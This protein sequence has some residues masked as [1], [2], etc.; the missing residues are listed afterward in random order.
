MWSK[1]GVC[2][3]LRNACQKLELRSAITKT[4]T[5]PTVYICVNWYACMC[6][7]TYICYSIEQRGFDYQTE[8]SQTID[9]RAQ[10]Y[11][12]RVSESDSRKG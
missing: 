11:V 10:V 4:Y 9:N 5:C 3:G 6:I 1:T 2:T 8:A 7:Y 12:R